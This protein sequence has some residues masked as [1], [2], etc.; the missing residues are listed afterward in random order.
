M[1]KVI[2]D[3]GDIFQ[4]KFINHNHS[5]NEAKRKR[6]ISSITKSEIVPAP[7]NQPAEVHD[8]F[9]ETLGLTFI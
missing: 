9:D 7:K 6:Y 5:T 2:M 8:S 4:S 1:G 3:L